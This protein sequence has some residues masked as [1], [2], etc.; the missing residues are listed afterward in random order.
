LSKLIISDFIKKN[1]NQKYINLRLF[2]VFGERDNWEYRL[3]PN[4]CAQAILGKDLKL[5]N[6]AIFDFIYI[7]DVISST[8]NILNKEVK[9]FDYNLS[10][11]KKYELYELAE[12]IVNISKK[13]LRI[14][15]SNKKIIAKYVGN[16]QRIKKENL[17]QKLT[18]IDQSIKNVYE[19][20]KKRKK[21]LDKKI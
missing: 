4:L 16:N 8:M 11:G 14:L 1:K 7:E 2:G 10:S 21:T 17:L 9:F 12:K 18:P 15:L 3:I 6:N 5:H 20:L 13:E 19:Y